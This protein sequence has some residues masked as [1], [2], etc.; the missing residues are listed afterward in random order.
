M[1]RA[2]FIFVYYVSGCKGSDKNCTHFQVKKRYEKWLYFEAE[3]NLNDIPEEEKVIILTFFDNRR[4]PIEL[5][6]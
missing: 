1:L 4:N 3:Q 5:K 2:I 6:F